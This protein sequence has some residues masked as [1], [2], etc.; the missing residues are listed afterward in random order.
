MSLFIVEDDAIQRF[1]LERM[2]ANLGLHVCG[3]SNNG[4]DSIVE[5]IRLKPDLILMD[6]Q[7]KD[8][9]SGI[10]VA[11]QTLNTYK[12]GIIFITA[13]SEKEHETRISGLASHH[14]IPKPVSYHKL[15]S[16]IESAQLALNLTG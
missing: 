4:A 3:T 6:V 8:S 12:P 16:A 7:L 13:N 1:V 11:R 14:F 15:Q 10:D 9:V 2:A 5:I